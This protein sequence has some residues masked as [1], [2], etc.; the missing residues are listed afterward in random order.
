MVLL[1][2]C[3]FIISEQVKLIEVIIYIIYNLWIFSSMISKQV[4]LIKVTV[5]IIY[6]SKTVNRERVSGEDVIS[7]ILILKSVKTPSI[8]N[9]E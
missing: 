4:K 1:V 9:R 2:T 6:S 7:S 5:Y 3:P 8:V